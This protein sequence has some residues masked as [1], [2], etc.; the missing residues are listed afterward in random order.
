MKIPVNRK[1]LP[2]LLK[3]GEG[4]ALEFKRS[5]AE[6]REGM[7]TVCAFLNGCGGMVLFGA[8]S[9]GMPEGQQ[10][11]DKTLREIAQ[12]FE[13]FEPPV[14]I[15]I[16]RVKV[17][18]DREVLVLSV[19]SS[20]ASRPCLFEG[21]PYER[22]ESATCRMPQ[23]NMKSSFWSAFIAGAVGR[24]LPPKKS[25]HEIW[26]ATRFFVFWMPPVLPVD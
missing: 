10:V 17:K 20:I 12:A 7:Q 25:N 26:T 22:L 4:L 14:N 11:S 6:L 15:D 19:D 9:D 24:M 3:R 2:R 23:E 16:R 21:R 8:R 18:D 13:R 5:T 1:Q